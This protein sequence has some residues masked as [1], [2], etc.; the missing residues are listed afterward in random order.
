MADIFRNSMAKAAPAKDFSLAFA[1]FWSSVIEFDQ[2]GGDLPA[3]IYVPGE[4]KNF[5]SVKLACRGKDELSR[6]LV[7]DADPAS[8]LSSLSNDI[9]T[10]VDASTMVSTARIAMD[11]Y[12]SADWTPLIQSLASNVRD[13]ASGTP[14]VSSSIQVLGLLRPTQS[15]ALSNIDQLI[16]GGQISGLLKT[17]CD[18]KD[19]ILS[20]ACLA[21]LIVSETDPVDPSPDFLANALAERPDMLQALND[22]LDEFQS[23]TVI[24]LV[25]AASQRNSALRGIAKEIFSYRVSI[26]RIGLLPTAGII[27][28]LDSYLS[29]LDPSLTET[30]LKIF[31]GYRSFWKVMDEES[32]A[33]NVTKIYRILIKCGD[34]VERAARKKLRERLA[35]ISGD[36]WKAAVRSGTS[37]YD[38]ATDFAKTL[39]GELELAALW[40]PLHEMTD[41]VLQNAARDMRERWFTF[42]SYLSDS[43]RKTLFHNVGEQIT[44]GATVSDVHEFLDIG[45]LRFIDEGGFSYAADQ[46]VRRIVYPS[47]ESAEGLAS[48][49]RWKSTIKSWTDISR[50]E[51]RDHLETLLREH[52]SKG[53]ASSSQATELLEEFALSSNSLG[54]SKGAGEPG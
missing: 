43:G 51:T 11:V 44:R 9:K 34:P 37:P 31:T 26:D 6:R 13:Q 15:A 27:R 46:S 3:A 16:A 54:D 25:H 41:E 29:L 18:Q 45:G 40:K 28:N 52:Q 47:L 2:E 38:I 10:T 4:A 35:A 22:F 21:L 49:V 30:F 33:G 42:A 23:D 39:A 53:E 19:N 50:S 7:T 14:V 32:L 36:E 24:G 17:A 12:E 1:H 20:G 48:L 5:F 8:A